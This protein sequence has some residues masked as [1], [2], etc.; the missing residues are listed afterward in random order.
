[1]SL[2]LC[3]R[4]LLL[5]ILVILGTSVLA[6]VGW[7]NLGRFL[8]ATTPPIHADAIVVL[9]GEGGRFMRTRHA[10]ELYAQGMAPLVVFSG[11]T[12]AST[13]I[14]CTS[15]ALSVEA[16]A[17]LGLPEE[18]VLLAPEAQSTLEEAAHLHHLATEQEWTTLLIVTDRFHTRRALRTLEAYLPGI[19]IQA[20]A[21][22]DPEYRPDR[23]WAN[24][25]SL[26][27]A[28]NELLKLGFYW[29]EYGIRP[30]G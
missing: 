1:M 27:F 15:T 14:A 26:V 11:G 3:R 10:V 25:R 19:E 4:L 2:Q 22:D 18:A 13:G 23:W 29:I 6:I 9:G 12:L 7:F 30:I 28:V 24:E 5:T 16:A 21:P 8:D 20:G 17:Q